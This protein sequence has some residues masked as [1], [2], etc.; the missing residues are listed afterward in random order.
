MKRYEILFRIKDADS[1][2]IKVEAKSEYL[3]VAKATNQ[4]VVLSGRLRDLYIVD[5][6]VRKID[7]HKP[8]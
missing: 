3:A 2:L 1:V 8:Y 4:G 6:E 7:W 5:V